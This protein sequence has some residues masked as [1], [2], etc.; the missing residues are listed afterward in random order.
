MRVLHVIPTLGFGGAERLVIDLCNVWSR[1]RTV[2]ASICALKPLVPLAAALDE[3]G[4][5]L[6][7]LGC[8][9]RELSRV[10]NWLEIPKL[11]KLIRC[12]R[13]D[14][15][16]THLRTADMFGRLAVFGLSCRTVTTLHNTDDFLRGAS[17][18]FPVVRALR[19][20][21]WLAKPTFAAITDA[22]AD[23]CAEPLRLDRKAVTVIPNGTDVSRFD[24]KDRRI[25]ISPGAPV[26]L[27]CVARMYPQKGHLGLLDATNAL[28]KRGLKFILRLIGD[29]PCKSQIAARIRELD[30]S[31][32]VIIV[33]AKHDVAPEY[34]D[35]E[36][37]VL[38]SAW[39]GQGIV[40]MEAMA[41]GLPVVATRVGGI[42][43]VV[44][45]GIE[46]F[47]VEPGDAEGM[48][49]RIEQLASDPD[50]RA[51]MGAA[52]RQR[53]VDEFSIEKCARRYEALYEEILSE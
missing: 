17:R 6:V 19:V 10:A 21:A 18:Q 13:P 29:G 41:S 33:E 4:T 27:V 49:G 2:E 36:I 3:G 26:R 16:H 15:V 25:P 20:S 23:W 34:W 42:P 45:D 1:S 31:D 8:R 30:M 44:R 50:L 53:A 32:T 22:V 38:N 35:S 47:L 46:G 52:G 48:A 43:D 40:L 11:R 39:E 9:G 24:G 5:R 14:I 7:T 37:F 12:L 28:R 51:R